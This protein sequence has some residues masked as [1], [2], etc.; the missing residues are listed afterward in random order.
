MVLLLLLT[1]IT[2]VAHSQYYYDDRNI[3]F[4]LGLGAGA[5][6]CI[7]DVGGAN[8]DKEFYINEIRSK[9]FKSSY[10]I[11][12]GVIIQDFIGARLEGTFGQV[13]SADNVITSKASLNLISKNVRN[14]N[15][16]SNISEVALLAEFHP[17]LIKY[18]EEGPLKI[19]PYAIA[20]VG[21]FSF[22][23]Q[24]LYNGA[25]INL[26][27]LHTEGQGFAEFEDR[28]PYKLSQFN[29]PFGIGVRYE[30]SSMLNIRLEYVHRKLFTDYLDD[31]SSRKNI[32][33]ALYAN[34]MTPVLARFASALAN[35]S[36][37]GDEPPRR[38]NPNDKDAYMTLSLKLGISLGRTFR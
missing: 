7:T 14:L 33:P 17:L 20:G 15:F 29:I 16:R 2:E 23:P 25:W 35:P 6:N 11:Y 27:P 38:A 10:S 36:K 24:T 21:F 26:Q 3:Y 18:R 32:N 34:Y 37:D 30:L 13:T 9:N 5:M 28:V 31:A 1:G 22:N 12:A 19:S 4:E 8:S